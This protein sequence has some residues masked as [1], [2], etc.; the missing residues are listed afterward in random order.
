[1]LTVSCMSFCLSVACTLLYKRV[2]FD[3]NDFNKTILV[4]QFAVY[5]LKFVWHKMY[6]LYYKTQKIRIFIIS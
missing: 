1:M 5:S 2:N 6:M 3:T 4:G